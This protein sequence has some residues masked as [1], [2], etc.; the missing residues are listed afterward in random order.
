[1]DDP[2]REAAEAAHLLA[3]LLPEEPRVAAA[4]GLHLAAEAEVPA[5][6]G[7]AGAHRERLQEVATAVVA[8][9]PLQ[10]WMLV[11]ARIARRR[12]RLMQ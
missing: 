5:R 8:T 1:M 7:L 11:A 6:L 10:R 9:G 2:Y 4:M 3:D 12:D